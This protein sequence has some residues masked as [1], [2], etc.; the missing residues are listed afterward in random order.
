M[1]LTSPSP[2]PSPYDEPEPDPEPEPYLEG[3]D[4]KCQRAYQ[5]RGAADAGKASDG[6][7]KADEEE[8]LAA[9]G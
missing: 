4:E 1:C 2:S 7:S 9:S 6:S 5:R 3:V 8:L